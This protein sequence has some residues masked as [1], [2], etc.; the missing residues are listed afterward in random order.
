MFDRKKIIFVC[1]AAAVAASGCQTAVKTI[2]PG[3]IS[4][5]PAQK[6][7]YSFEPDA[8][9]PVDPDQGAPGD[10][11]LPAVQADFDQNRAEEILDKTAISPDKQRILAVYHHAGDKEA[12]FRM[13]MY[14]GD[15][16]LLRKISPDAMAISL[17]D[18][19]VWAPDSSTAAF[20]GV[21]R[22]QLQPATATAPPPADAPTP[23]DPDNGANSNA[24]IEAN[25][26]AANNNAA[27]TNTPAQPVAPLAPIKLFSNEQVYTVSKDGADLKYISQKDNVIYFYLAWSP[28]GT[29]LATLAATPAEWHYGELYSKSKG[30]EFIPA[31]RPRLI[32][33][34]GRERLLDDNLSAVH[35]TWSPD[36]GKLACAF[37]KDV[38]IYDTAGESPTYAAI[39]LRQPLLS[40]SF[41]YDQKLREQL[42][43]NSGNA[44]TAPAAQTNQAVQVMPKES[45]LVSFNPIV[46]LR[47]VDEKTIY[48]Q[49]GYIKEML[50]S[51]YSSR[52]YLRWHKINLSSP[53]AATGAAR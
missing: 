43:A 48:A 15:G 29:M 38:K 2:V 37:D 12:E 18:V 9:P 33:K 47:W 35:P 4:G 27:N 50:D 39:Q 1:I 11:R 5:V 32:D 22:T 20:L 46:E 24:N 49:T 10:E 19:I 51:R 28:D 52:S 13:D 31:G 53:A 21:A 25:V 36:S 23:P 40:S 42:N 45:D 17:P 14:L 44:P 16:K 26:G 6:L 7:S 41:Q 34:T 30:E 3:S 8:L